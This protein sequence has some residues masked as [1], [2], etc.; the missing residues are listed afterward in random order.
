MTESSSNG[1]PSPGSRKPD[2]TTA[3]AP[4]LRRTETHP[5]GEAIVRWCL[6]L[7]SRTLSI[8]SIRRFPPP[9][10][11]TPCNR[12]SSSTIRFSSQPIS[13]FTACS[14]TACRSS[15][16]RAGRVAAISSASSISPI[17]RPQRLARRQPVH[18]SGGS[19]FHNLKKSGFE[20]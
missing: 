2:T 8:C 14:S 10:A 12:C 6:P 17:P 3:S 4:T 13:C 15:T 1:K 5:N 11:K 9:P 16:C 18:R 7:A 19:V 20:H